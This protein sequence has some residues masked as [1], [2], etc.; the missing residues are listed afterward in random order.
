M[1]AATTL[2]IDSGD[3][4]SLAS[5]A[6]EAEPAKLILWHPTA[7]GALAQRLER[8]VA[9]HAEAF[10]AAELVVAPGFQPQPSDRN[11]ASLHETQLLIAAA[12]A[13]RRCGCRR[14]VWPRHTG[15]DPEA[16]GAAVERAELVT[17]LAELEAALAGPVIDLP[18]VDLEDW[19]LADLAEDAGVP[20]RLF[21]PCGRG[22]AE[23][24]GSC[25][26]CRRWA[27]AMSLAK[28]PWPWKSA[29]VSVGPR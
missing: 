19:R 16:L 26:G 2:L 15:P 29:A 5:I 14:I 12:I 4:A 18:V 9:E 7:E 1:Q 27:E 28:V 11:L 25:A 20:L 22:A 13:A 17:A 23:P 6:L 10:G 24:C 8:I 3:L 21:W